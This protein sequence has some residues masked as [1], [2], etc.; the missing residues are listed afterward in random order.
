MPNPASFVSIPNF[1]LS[2]VRLF[3]VHS[4]SQCDST[5]PSV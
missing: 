3:S 4:V 1:I 2:G 5:R